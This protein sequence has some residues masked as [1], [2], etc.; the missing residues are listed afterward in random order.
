VTPAKAFALTKPVELVIYARGRSGLQDAHGRFI[1]GGKNV[2]LFPTPGSVIQ[3]D[4]STGTATRTLPSP[5][6]VDAL[7]KREELVGKS[8]AAHEWPQQLPR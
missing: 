5:A 1:N 2:V 4:Q 6:A 3:I 8:G 7:R